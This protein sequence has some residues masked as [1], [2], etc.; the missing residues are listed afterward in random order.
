MHGLSTCK[1]YFH[2]HCAL[3]SHTTITYHVCALLSNTLRVVVTCYLHDP[4]VLLLHISRF[5]FACVAFM[6][7]HHTLPLRFAF[8]HHL[9]TLLSRSLY[10]YVIML[11]SS[12]LTCIK[13]WR[14]NQSMKKRSQDDWRMKE[15]IMPCKR[16]TSATST[17]TLRDVFFAL[18][19]A[20]QLKKSMK[21]LS[22]KCIPYSSS[23]ERTKWG[24]MH[25]KCEQL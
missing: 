10:T 25:L 24:L 14:L 9:Y 13:H 20:W 3:W 21:V 1:L 15:M 6:F 7:N 8:A 16:F 5:V 12:Y 23:M 17:L 4:R 11:R 18:H 19:L 22:M 2:T